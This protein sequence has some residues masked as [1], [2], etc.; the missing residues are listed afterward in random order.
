MGIKLGVIW[1][2][3]N[4][5]HDLI[6]LSESH[7]EATTLCVKT[8][9]GSFLFPTKFIATFFNIIILYISVINFSSSILFTIHGQ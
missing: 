8:L 2:V 1:V 9:P 4:S 5:S 3:I 6:Q 7:E